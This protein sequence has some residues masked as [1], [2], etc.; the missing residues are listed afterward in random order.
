MNINVVRTLFTHLSLTGG[1]V[2][3]PHDAHAND[4]VPQR[5]RRVQVKVEAGQVKIREVVGI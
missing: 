3:A 5:R 1:V 2:A 4:C